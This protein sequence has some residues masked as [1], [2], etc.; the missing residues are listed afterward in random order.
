MFGAKG[1]FTSGNEE[2]LLLRPRLVL[3]DFLSAA[4]TLKA[5]QKYIRNCS[6][7]SIFNAELK[8]LLR[9]QETFPHKEVLLVLLG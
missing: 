8:T 7:Q 9:V 6:L 1:H 5:R 3:N 2:E 4:N